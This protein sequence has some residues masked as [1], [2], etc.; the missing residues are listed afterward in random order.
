[1]LEHPAVQASG[2]VGIPDLATNNKSRAFVV[3]KPGQKCTQD[4]ICKFVADRLPEYKHLHGGV[5][6]LDKLPVN[7]GGKMDR[8]ALLELALKQS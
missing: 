3:L 1:L 2:V 8:K 5:R 4:E 6:F 7:K